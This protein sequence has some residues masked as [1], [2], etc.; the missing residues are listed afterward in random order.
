MAVTEWSAE[1]SAPQDSSGGTIYTYGD[2]PATPGEACCRITFGESRYFIMMPCIEYKGGAT[3]LFKCPQTESLVMI[4]SGNGYIVDMTNPSKLSR[5]DTYP[6]LSPVITTA[7]FVVVRSYSKICAIFSIYV[8]IYKKY[9][10]GEIENISLSP[11]HQNR[12]DIYLHDPSEEDEYRTE[13]MDLSKSEA[14]I[15]V[16]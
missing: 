7:D 12:I 6:I 15:T 2:G 14:G 11:D 9:E 1:W 3:G 10:T 8:D 16:T 4:C 5:I 13:N